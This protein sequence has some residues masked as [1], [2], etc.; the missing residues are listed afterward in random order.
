MHM[1]QSENALIFPCQLLP[2]FT[3][4]FKSVRNVK[5]NHGGGHK[6]KFSSTEARNLNRIVRRSAEARCQTLGEITK[7]T[8]GICVD[9]PVSPSA[10]RIEQKKLILA[11]Y[12]P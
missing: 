10:A 4:G 2:I 12:R 1:P 7:I 3:S 11:S 9:S 6:L 5:K 8:N